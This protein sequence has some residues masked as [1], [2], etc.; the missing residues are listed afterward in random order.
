MLNGKKTTNNIDFYNNY[1]SFTP[2]QNYKTCNCAN[3]GSK[4]NN[5]TPNILNTKLKKNEIVYIDL[6]K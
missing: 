4:C 1:L 5:C 2:Q 6:L 3:S